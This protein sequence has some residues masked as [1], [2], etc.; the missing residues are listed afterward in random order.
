VWLLCKD[1]AIFMRDSPVFTG[2]F[3]EI[4]VAKLA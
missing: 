4:Y 3:K 2:L 1:L